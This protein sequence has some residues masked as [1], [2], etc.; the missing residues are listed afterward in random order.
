MRIELEGTF[1][2]FL[3]LYVINYNVNNINAKENIL[4]KE[5]LG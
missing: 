2:L 5:V 3:T 4:L 1:C